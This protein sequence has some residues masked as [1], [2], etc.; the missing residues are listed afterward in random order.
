MPHATGMQPD[1]VQ[2]APYLIPAVIVAVILRRNLRPRPL[3]I[4]RLWVWPTIL[5][6]SVASNLVAQPPPTDPITIG[7][8]TAMFSLG[9]VLGWQRG[10]FT[11]I[12]VHPETHDLTSKSSPIGLMFI[13][14]IFLAKFA[15]RT[16]DLRKFG[17][18]ISAGALADASLV[19]A[20]ALMV[21]QRL[22]IWVRAR[23]LLEEA[24]AKKAAGGAVPPTIVS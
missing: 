5:F 17:L 1:W 11:H 19:L 3:N 6:V 10:R 16:V 14:L 23:R 24:V 20:M 7:L 15:L 22:E 8:L 4:E 2:V 21:T 9:A 18:P 13:L 12:E